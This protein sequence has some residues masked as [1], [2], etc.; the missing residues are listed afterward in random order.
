[1]RYD[2]ALPAAPPPPTA[3]ATHPN[4]HLRRQRLLIGVC[5]AF[6][7]SPFL[8]WMLSPP[9][10]DQ[11]TT[12]AGSTSSSTVSTTTSATTLDTS[13]R[14][15]AG[16]RAGASARFGSE[17]APSTETRSSSAPPAARQ[18][19]TEPPATATPAPPSTERP[20]LNHPLTTVFSNARCH[21]SYSG[22]VP[23]AED[24]DCADGD[25]DGPVYVTGPFLVTGDDVYG[26][27]SNGDKVACS[28]GDN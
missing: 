16:G 18:H 13:P 24:V 2:R 20:T 17:T 21:G 11:P 9:A 23:V 4:L 26:I 15:G 5:L 14:A 1:M 12:A 19:S 25:G 8:M 27:D 10:S 22:C 7:C 28:D 3:T 6:A